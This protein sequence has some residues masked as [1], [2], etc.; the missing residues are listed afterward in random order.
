MKRQ[1]TLTPLDLLLRQRPPYVNQP[2]AGVAR[3]AAVVEKVRANWTETPSLD[4][5]L[6]SRQRVRQHQRAEAKMEHRKTTA[7]AILSHRQRRVLAAKRRGE[8]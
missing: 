4:V 3:A 2:G 5:N 6:G 7:W 1:P 8:A